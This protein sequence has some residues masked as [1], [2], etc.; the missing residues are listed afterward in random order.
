MLGIG[1]IG[2]GGVAARQRLGQVDDQ[3]SIDTLHYAWDKGVNFVDTTEL[4]GNGHSEEV[5]GRALKQWRKDKIY[6]ATKVRPLQ[7]PNPDDDAPQMVDRFPVWYVRE[8]YALPFGWNAFPP[9]VIT[10]ARRAGN[11]TTPPSLACQRFH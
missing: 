9:S 6:V 2:T 1:F 10:P 7:W 11:R 3:A 5:V 4:Y 8:A